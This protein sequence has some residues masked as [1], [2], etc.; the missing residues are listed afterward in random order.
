M[1]QEEFMLPII[2]KK[3]SITDIDIVYKDGQLYY[4]NTS[5][6]QPAIKNI[7]NEKI[8]S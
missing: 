7:V 6:I 8:Q 1:S 4:N 3:N 2:T 5:N